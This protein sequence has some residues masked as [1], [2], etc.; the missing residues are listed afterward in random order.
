MPI[1]VLHRSG[2][3]TSALN[4]KYGLAPIPTLTSSA[5]MRR[6]GTP[7]AP[8]TSPPGARA[9]STPALMIAPLELS[10]ISAMSGVSDATV[11]AA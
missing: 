10:V 8:L 5:R 3:V 4:E 9:T 1:G 2:N 6:S 7:K 11:E